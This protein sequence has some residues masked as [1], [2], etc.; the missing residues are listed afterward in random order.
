MKPALFALSALSIGGPAISVPALAA[1]TIQPGYWEARDEVLSPIHTT[2]T[3]RRC[4]TPHDVDKFMSCHI[5]HIYQCVCPEQTAA[6]GVVAF[7]GQCVDKKGRKVGISGHGAYTPTSL[8]MTADVTFRLLGIPMSGE[9]RTE[10]HRLGDAC[11]QAAP[12]AR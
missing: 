5:N 4:I 11:P 3:E 12:A 1:D 8:T 2:K 6:G 10:A 9:A 7:K